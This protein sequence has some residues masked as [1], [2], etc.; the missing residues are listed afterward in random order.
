VK[1]KQK[2]QELTSTEVIKHMG[3]TEVIKHMSDSP[4]VTPF[5]RRR[6]DV[7]PPPPSHEAR[8]HV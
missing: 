7:A 6:A 4:R 3:K 8:S 2:H 5:Y 1:I